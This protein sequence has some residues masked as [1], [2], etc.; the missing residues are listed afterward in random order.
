M[1]VFSAIL[2]VV[3]G[4]LVSALVALLP[5]LHIYNVLG[6]L[7][8]LLHGARTAGV[9]VPTEACLPF[10][11]GMVCGWSMLNTISSV[12]LGAPDESAVFTVLPGQKYLMEGRGHEGVMLVGAG[13]LAGLFLLVAVA[14]PLAPRFLPV[15]QAVLMPQMH[16]ILWCIIAFMLMS[17]WPRESGR[18]TSGW[19][20]F[21]SAWKG[22]F[23]GLLTFLLSGL[24]GFVLL[25]RSPVSVDVAFQNIMPAFVGLFA[26]PWCLLN[27]VS[28]TQ[29][30]PQRIVQRLE[31][32][33]DHLLRGAAAGGLGGGF[34]AFFPVVTG[35]VGGMLAGHATAQRD[36]RVFLVSQG[37]SKMIYYT[38]ALLLLFAP[39]LHLVRGG[40]AWILSGLAAPQGWGDYFLALGCIALSGGLAFLLLSP[41]ARAVLW[42][43]GRVAYQRISG[44]ALLV[45]AL[46]VFFATGWPGIAIA[47]VATGI[48]LIPVLYGSRRLNCLGILLLPIACNLS[49]CGATVAAWLGLL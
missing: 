10:A 38:G 14:G 23:A 24:L 17:E 31:I 25:Y 6:L 7:A 40:G 30:P 11:I 33:A 13:G 19:A 36:E 42:L 29:P 32:G 49:G 46:V 12:L 44:L 2:G 20:R 26:V 9:E 48:G 4:T 39:G 37:A 5:G 35:G 1:A 27:L 8:I 45:I 34:A 28:A 22:L 18:G 15:A 43:M 16:W 21:S 3:L 41:L 47:L